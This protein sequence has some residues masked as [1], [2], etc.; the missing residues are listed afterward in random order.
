MKKRC[1]VCGEWVLEDS[2]YCPRCGCSLNENVLVE[3]KYSAPVES[4]YRPEQ[5]YTPVRNDY[6]E[7]GSKKGFGF[8]LG[9][10]LGLIGLLIGV[11][12]YPSG[13]E[14]RETFVK[15]WLT[16][17]FV[18]IGLG[19]LVFLVVTASSSLS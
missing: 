4:D 5:H 6:K 17:W 10:F 14:R 7:D 19:V 12:M 16:S 9:F 8:L 18:G 15:G 1:K 11:C 2:N 13:S 3:Q